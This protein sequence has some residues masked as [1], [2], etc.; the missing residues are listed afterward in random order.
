MRVGRARVKERRRRRER[1]KTGLEKRERKRRAASLF[2]NALSKDGVK[3][4]ARRRQR[5]EGKK[6]KAENPLQFFRWC[7]REREET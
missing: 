4:E 7:K 2:D 6:E 1:R 3:G 5:E